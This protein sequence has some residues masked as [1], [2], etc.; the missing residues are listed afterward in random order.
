ML[1]EWLQK[2]FRNS[3]TVLNKSES[4]E[5]TEPP[6]KEGGGEGRGRRGEGGGRG[7]C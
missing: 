1:C 5:R 3:C 4:A 2:S 6:R 7:L